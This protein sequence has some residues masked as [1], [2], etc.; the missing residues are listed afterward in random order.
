MYEINAEI[1]TFRS[2]FCAVNGLLRVNSPQQVFLET[3]NKNYVT[4]SFSLEMFRSQLA[5]GTE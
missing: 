3:L 2:M 5:T 4:I 1:N